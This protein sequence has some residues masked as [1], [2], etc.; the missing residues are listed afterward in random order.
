[1]CGKYCCKE[2]MT[3][4]DGSIILHDADGIGKEHVTEEESR[5]ARTISDGVELWFNNNGDDIGWVFVVI[6]ERWSRLRHQ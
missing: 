6:E 3:K 5:T 1:M 4:T 2:L